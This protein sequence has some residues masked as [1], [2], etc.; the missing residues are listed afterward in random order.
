MR[1]GLGQAAASNFLGVDGAVVNDDGRLSA[2]SAEEVVVDSFWMPI[3][4]KAS[5]C[6]FVS[7]HPTGATV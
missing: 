4:E 2:A 5:A 6:N 1:D 7:S 3:T